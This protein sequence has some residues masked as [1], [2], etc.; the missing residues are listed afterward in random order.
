MDPDMNKYDLSHRVSHHPKMSDEA[1]EETYHAAWSAFYTPEH[2]RT[3]LRRS[4]ASKLGRPGTTLSTLLW[5]KLVNQFEGVHPLEGGAF[6][7]KSRRDRRGSMP[8]ENPLVFYPRY[9]GQTLRKLWGYYSV[10]RE[11]K[12]ILNE[13]LNAPDRWTYSDL[14]IEPPKADEFEALD[15]YHATAGGEA[16]LARKRRGDAIREHAHA[17]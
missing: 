4:A 3:V 5:F 13:V 10:Y 16:A 12:A 8:R 7:L 2:I 15:L 1:W 11:C 9:L 6:R 17:H 14:A